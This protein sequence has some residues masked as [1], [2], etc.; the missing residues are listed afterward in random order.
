MLQKKKL[1]KTYLPPSLAERLRAA[2]E[3]EGLSESSFVKMMIE[4]VVGADEEPEVKPSKARREGKLTLRLGKGVRSKIEREAK[5]QGVPPSTWAA[6]IVTARAL[7]APQPIQGER[8]AIRW[9]FQQLRGATTNLNQ[10]A[11]A[12]NRDVFTGGSYAP[13]RQELHELRSAV[14]GLRDLLRMYAAGR[15]EFQLGEELSD[16]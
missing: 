10:M 6:R 7:A 16:K 4:T 12:M 3:R 5:S 2:A 1:V 15:L 14:D 11:T 9:G 8:K 13:T